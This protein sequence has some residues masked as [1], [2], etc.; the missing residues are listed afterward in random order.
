MLGTQQSGSIWRGNYA[1]N[2]EERCCRGIVILD[3]ALS[4]IYVSYESE[5]M[6]VCRIAM[7]THP[8]N[9]DVLRQ[10]RNTIGAFSPNAAGPPV[11]QNNSGLL[12]S[13]SYSVL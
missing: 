12:Q 10:A 9:T 2:E 6:Q 11:S 1:E 7:E 13:N 8:K 3:L 4:I 5:L